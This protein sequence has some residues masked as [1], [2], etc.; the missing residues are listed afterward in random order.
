MGVS[1]AAMLAWR[2]RRAGFLHGLVVSR[3]IAVVA[4][5]FSTTAFPTVTFPSFVRSSGVVTSVLV[6]T[7]CRARQCRLWRALQADRLRS[8][9]IRLR[10]LFGHALSWNLELDEPLNLLQQSAL[11]DI[12]E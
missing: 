5:A 6:L 8:Y 4:T 3:A 1:V 9:F 2:V 11:F 7:I 12:A 10:H